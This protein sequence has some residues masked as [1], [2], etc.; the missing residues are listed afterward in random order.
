MNFYE[1][2][3]HFQGIFKSIRNPDYSLQVEHS[4]DGFLLIN[5][6]DTIL[7]GGGSGPVV[8]IELHGH[9]KEV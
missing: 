8:H 6:S 2:V 1:F 4:M 3:F 7:L 9:V 5:E